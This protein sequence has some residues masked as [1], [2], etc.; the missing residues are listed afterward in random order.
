MTREVKKVVFTQQ[1]APGNQQLR[2]CDNYHFIISVNR[3]LFDNFENM[4]YAPFNTSCL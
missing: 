2:N 4:I 1:Q 3:E